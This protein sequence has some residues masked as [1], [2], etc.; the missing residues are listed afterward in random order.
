MSPW[1][2]CVNNCACWRKVGLARRPT[3]RTG[4]DG[5]KSDERPIGM[6]EHRAMA[7][8][9][10]LSMDACIFLVCATLRN[11]RETRSYTREGAKVYS[12]C[13][14]AERFRLRFELDT[15]HGGRE[16]TGIELV[17]LCW[18]SGVDV[19]IT[20]LPFNFPRYRT[21][22]ENAVELCWSVS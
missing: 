3:D 5:I 15:L 8:P 19:S 14:F 16:V 6:R 21:F 4:S 13:L 9:R 17:K 10:R 1:D 18:L 7:Y 11:T 22:L 2:R 20:H 12:S